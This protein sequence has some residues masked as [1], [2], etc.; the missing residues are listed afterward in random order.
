MKRIDINAYFGHWQYWDLHHKTPEDLIGLM[1][2]FGIEQSA[3]LSLRGVFV[4]WRA[5]NDETFDAAG[6][7]PDR[8]LP[9]VTLSPFLNGGADELNRLA[10]RGAR[11][12]RL[13]PTFHSYRLDSRFVDEICEAAGRRDLPVMIPTRIMMNWRF[14]PIVTDQIGAVALR[15]PQTQFI[16]SGPNYLAEFQLLVQ[17]MQRASNLS[18]EI[19]CMQGFGAIARLVGEVG[20]GRVLLGTGAVLNYPA[21]NVAKL[22]GADLTDDQR[23]TIAW[24]NAA[25]LL[26]LG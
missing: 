8:L 12:V 9:A 14:V 10:D 19:T 18:Y 4:D 21:C 3:V 15:H 11:C 22:D 20:V 2:R 5:G 23:E 25:N 13:Y 16:I 6:R 1:D 7:H 26:K 17:W 24:R